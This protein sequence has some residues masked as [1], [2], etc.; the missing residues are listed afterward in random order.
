MFILFSQASSTLCLTK[1]LGFQSKKQNVLT[2]S[3]LNFKFAQILP[4][5]N[6]PNQTASLNSLINTTL[7]I[8]KTLTLLIKTQTWSGTSSVNTILSISSRNTCN[9]KIFMIFDLFLIAFFVGKISLPHV[10]NLV[11]Q[12]LHEK[13]EKWVVRQCQ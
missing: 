10:Q 5:T 12:E 9:T 6:T 2:S 4:R 11:R 8:S 7:L 3:Q 13:S 1:I